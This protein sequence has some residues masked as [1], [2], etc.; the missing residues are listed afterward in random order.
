MQP[1]KLILYPWQEVVGVVDSIETYEKRVVFYISF[2]RKICLDIPL[3]EIIPNNETL[4]QLTGRNISILRTNQ[5]YFLK[6]C[7]LDEDPRS[8]VTEDE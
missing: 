7:N 2:R 4:A 3:D 5:K 8:I 1:E 6:H